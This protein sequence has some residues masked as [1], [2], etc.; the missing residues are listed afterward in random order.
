M[1]ATSSLKVHVWY[2]NV[3]CLHRIC[4][5]VT[6]FCVWQIDWKRYVNN[7]LKVTGYTVNE[8]ELILVYEPGFMEKVSNL[9]VA[10]LKK[11]DGNM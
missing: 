8:T 2:V 1:F 11:P 6:M 5:T 4:S 7:L 3:E 9:V 10:T